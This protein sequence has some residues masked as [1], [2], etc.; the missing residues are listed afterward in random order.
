M[1]QQLVYVL[2]LV[3]GLLVQPS[4]AQNRQQAT[5][6][7][8]QEYFR[9][10]KWH[11]AAAAYESL[12][13]SDTSNALFWYRL[14]FACQNLHEYAKAASSYEHAATLNKNPFT[15]YN[16]ACAYSR[17]NMKEK[18]LRSLRDAADAGFNQP[19]TALSD[20]DL[21]AIRSEPEF[22]TVLTRIRSN[23]AP[24]ENDP[25]HRQFDFWIGEWNVYNQAGQLAGTSSVQNILEGCVVFENWTGI[26]GY[27]GKSFNFVDPASGNWR[28]TWVDSRGGKI[29]FT[30]GLEAGNMVFY[31]DSKDA[32]G[33]PI[34]RKLTF[35][36]MSRDKV[37]QFSQRSTD[38][39]KTW[40]VEYDF[41][42][43]R[44]QSR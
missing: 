22:D 8:A 44:K 17:L 2:W 15:F 18:A 37:R 3:L 26:H 4:A 30:G 11:D 20:E 16:L 25:T 42:Y 9:A 41:T 21:A 31:A 38:D 7:Q 32:G 34:R 28:Q 39:G 5:A 29:E 19:S 40:T 43:L 12:L 33:N 36:N 35:F 23:A 13:R 14:G 10:S 1:R 24:C 6:D 27:A